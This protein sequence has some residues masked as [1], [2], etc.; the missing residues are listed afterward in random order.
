MASSEVPK[1]FCKL[2][3]NSCHYYTARKN[4]YDRHLSTSKHQKRENA[5]KIMT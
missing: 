2:Y 1:S 3:C 4:Q 5:S